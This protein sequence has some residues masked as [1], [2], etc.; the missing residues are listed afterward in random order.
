MVNLRISMVVNFE[1]RNYHGIILKIADV[2]VI[3]AIINENTIHKV[4]IVVSQLNCIR[5]EHSC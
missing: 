3:L 1:I 2:I 4:I 5:L